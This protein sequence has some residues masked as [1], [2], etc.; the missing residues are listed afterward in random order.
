MKGRVCCCLVLGFAVAHHVSA[1]W[2]P[3]LNLSN[4][5]AEASWPKIALGAD[6]RI[7]VAWRDRTGGGQS[8][9]YR[10]AVQGAW[11]PVQNLGTATW[12]QG[13]KVCVDGVGLVHVVWDAKY[14]ATYDWDIYYR[15][16]IGTQWSPVAAI[17]Q[18][19]NRSVD[20]TLTGIPDTSQLYA[21]WEESA[22]PDPDHSRNYCWGRR[23]NNGWQSID[24]ISG[25]GHGQYDT[26][27]YVDP[28]VV[29]GPG[30]AIHVVYC[31]RMNPE[32]GSNNKI[33]DIWYRRFNG[34]AWDAPVNL[35]ASAQPAWAHA[36]DIALDGQGNPHV[37]FAWSQGSGTFYVYHMSWLGAAWSAPQVL[38]TFNDE[39]QLPTIAID[40]NN[41]VHVIW[42]Q[43]G[44]GGSDLLYRRRSN[45]VWG[46][47]VNITQNP[48]WSST[49]DLAIDALGTLHLV[50]TDSLQGPADVFYRYLDT[51][52][53]PTRTATPT[54]SPTATPTHTLTPTRT[55][56][57]R[58]T[59]TPTPTMADTRPRTSFDTW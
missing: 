4:N 47:I 23:W 38:S 34:A 50:Y 19:P 27:T 40:G 54:F 3:P 32:T 57:P 6:G 42:G 22:G 46:A 12:E 7:H 59:P 25:S 16:L 53:L 41:D 26:Q 20:V 29:A 52:P 8:P 15:T 21:V 44:I 10:Q 43:K 37:V 33:H 18:T 39:A 28:A 11:Q 51:Q 2:S 9:Y 31:T 24:N 30:G 36:P 56:T 1:Q 35:T 58:A 48:T 45:G 17:A 5:A 55:N 49:P 13:I 14:D